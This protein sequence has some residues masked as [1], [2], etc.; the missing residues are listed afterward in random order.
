MAHFVLLK[1]IVTGRDIVQEGQKSGEREKSLVSLTNF[2]N[3]GS[4]KCALI[5]KTMQ[6]LIHAHKISA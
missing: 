4:Y 3:T 5:D 1:K 2:R 6:I